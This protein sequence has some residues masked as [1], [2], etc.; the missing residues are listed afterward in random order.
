MF[1][2]KYYEPENENRKCEFCEKEKIIQELP[3][4]TFSTGIIHYRHI[5]INFESFISSSYC[6]QNSF[7][8]H[9]LSLAVMN[10]SKKEMRKK[11][12]LCK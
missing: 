10:P 11:S 8:P 12:V 6:G 3:G 4:S 9:V 1:L 7:L 5:K 2:P